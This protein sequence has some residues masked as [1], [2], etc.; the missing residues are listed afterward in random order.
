MTPEYDRRRAQHYLELAKA[1]TD[2]ALSSSFK[3]LAADCLEMAEKA[4]ELDPRK[5][6]Q[7][8]PEQKQE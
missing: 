2:P 4:E 7:V 8:A 1:T 3:I 6:Q 5:Q